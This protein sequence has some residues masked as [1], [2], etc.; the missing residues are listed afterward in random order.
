VENSVAQLAHCRASGAAHCSQNFAATGFS[1]SHAGHFILNPARNGQSIASL[2]LKGCILSHKAYV[3]ARNGS[4]L[5]VLP[6][7]RSSGILQ[8]NLIDTHFAGL[9][10][11]L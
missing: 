2:R 10:S 8:R 3:V 4:R 5:P 7:I 6:D 9:K 1:C 11:L